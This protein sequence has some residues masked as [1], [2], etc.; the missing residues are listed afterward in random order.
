MARVTLQSDLI[1]EIGSRIVAGSYAPGQMLLTQALEADFDL[2]RTVVREALKVLESMQLL[3]IK[4]SVGITILDRSR[5][6]VYDPRIIRWR[7]AGSARADQLRSLTE[8]RIA[9]EPIAAGL[10]AR[11][12]TGAQKS[13]LLELSEQM[14]ASAAAGLYETFIEQD[15]RFHGLLL[16]ASGNEMFVG[17]G[18]AIGAVVQGYEGD[19]DAKIARLAEHAVSGHGVV[20]RYIADGDSGAAETV[21]RT[22]LVGAKDGLE[23]Q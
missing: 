23:A 12:A 10:A 20:A 1:D 6:N 16:E 4:R 21:V 11:A 5:W 17:L 19:A 8:L 7:L 13:E 22:L 18:G 15:I 2:S 9:V 3:E 14:G